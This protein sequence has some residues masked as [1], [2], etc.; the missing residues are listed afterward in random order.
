MDQIAQY[1]LEFAVIIG[2]VLLNAFF[3][4]S[5]FSIV[6]V[7]Q[8]RVSL[9]ADKGD[10]RAR[11]SLQI[12]AHMNEYLSACQVGITIASLGLGWLGEEYI[13]GII[14][15]LFNL[16]GITPVSSGIIAGILGFGTIT[17]AHI[18][19]GE[20]AP[21]AFSIQFA[22]TTMLWTSIPLRLFYIVFYPA[23]WTL[24]AAS[25]LVL[26]L[27]RLPSPST[28]EFSHSPEELKMIVKE[29][30]DSGMLSADSAQLMQRVLTFTT[31]TVKDI[32]V[33]RTNVVGLDIHARADEIMDIAIENGYS[34][35]PVF[36]QTLDK[37]MGVVYVKDFLA[38]SENRSLIHISD[39]MR[40]AFFI[41]EGMKTGQLLKEFQKRKIHMAI[42]VDE[43]GMTT[44]LVTMEDVIEE[45]VGEI[46]DE[47]DTEEERIQRMAD[48]SLVVD[49]TM[50]INDLTQY[51]NIHFPEKGEFESI[52]GFLLHRL[53]RIPTGGES[54]TFMDQTFIVADVEQHRINK[55]KIILKQKNL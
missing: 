38:A 14:L 5:E 17:F 47:Y 34:R 26:K 27:F 55:V 9:L 8:T 3:V 2:L 33:P 51:H 43:Y 36:D 42:V 16:T 31:R 46:Q 24:N 4:A 44:G 21:K 53:G 7:R 28:H 32:M 54:V 11:F 52:G 19:A 6:K 18:V 49:G 1:F 10:I 39:F 48:G 35:M 15:R 41:P 37:I 40:P 45:I 20:M 25:N 30:G 12:I 23:I 13:S 50:S 22:E 29:S